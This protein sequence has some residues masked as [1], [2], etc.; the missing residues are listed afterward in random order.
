[1]RVVSFNF[2]KINVEKFSD[3]FDKV[4]VKSNIDILDVSSLKQD[5]FKTKEEFLGMKFKFGL[6]Y[7]PE[8]AKI[9]LFGDVILTMEDK[10]VKDIL[11]DW[12]DEKHLPDDIKIDIFNVI[13]RKAHLKALQ[14]EEDLNLPAHINLPIIRKEDSKN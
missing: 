14:L 5:I 7:E 8:I 3:T 10:L 4:T 12:K 2:K 13:L 11:K 6:D 1:M 9:E